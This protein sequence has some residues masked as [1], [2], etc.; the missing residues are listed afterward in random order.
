[1]KQGT[2]SKTEEP[3]Y[4]KLD[5]FRE[6]CAGGRVGG[7]AVVPE[8][9][10]LPAFPLGRQCQAVLSKAYGNPLGLCSYEA[11]GRDTERD[12]VC[13]CKVGGCWERLLAPLGIPGWRE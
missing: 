13:V 7:A 3:A 8:W 10:V 9:P 12:P 1:M 11:R 6:I 5:V 4:T 2:A